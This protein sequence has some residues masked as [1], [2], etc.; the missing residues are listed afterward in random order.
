MGLP[1]DAP[2]FLFQLLL[3]QYASGALLSVFPTQSL[4]SYTLTDGEGSASSHI[5]AGSGPTTG[6]TV[7]TVCRLWC[8][9]KSKRQ[10]ANTSVTTSFDDLNS[11]NYMCMVPP[12]DR[13]Q[14]LQSFVSLQTNIAG[15]INVS[16]W[17]RPFQSHWCVLQNYQ[18]SEHHR[19]MVGV[20]CKG[21]F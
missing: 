12:S 7:W 20:K 19:L 5:Q 15:F 14:P 13:W 9:V 18:D 6:Q 1:Q 4:R 11:M 3:E 2:R 17:E 21:D 16:N 10:L 8:H